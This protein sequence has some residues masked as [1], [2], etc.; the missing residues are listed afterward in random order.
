M[1]SSQR[2]IPA[3]YQNLAGTKPPNNRYAIWGTSGGVAGQQVN[4]AVGAAFAFLVKAFL[5]VAVA[6]AHDQAAWKTIKSNP[7]KA[8]SVDGLFASKTN[9]LS[10]VNFSL[11]KRSMFTMALALVYWYV[12]PTP[13]L[14]EV[15]H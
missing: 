10:L 7:T 4:I 13:T 15:A 2:V 5:G 8:A 6:T 3:F 11:W 1:S 14:L 9:I 12:P